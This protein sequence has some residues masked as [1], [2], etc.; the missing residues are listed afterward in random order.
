MFYQNDYLTQNVCS[1]YQARITEENGEIVLSNGI[2]ERRFVTSDG[3]P[4]FGKSFSVIN[5]SGKDIRLNEFEAELLALTEHDVGNT[6]VLRNSQQARNIFAVSDIEN[7][8]TPTFSYHPYRTC[9]A[10]LYRPYR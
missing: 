1:G 2:A 3:I 4:A 8:V 9:A 5:N 10:L 7:T 6:E